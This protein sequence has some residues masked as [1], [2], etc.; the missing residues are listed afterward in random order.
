V[1]AACCLLAIRWAVDQ[2]NNESVLFRESERFG[3]GLWFRHLVRDR[4]AMPTAGEA[5]LCGVLLLIIRF[6]AG[7]VMPPPANW[8][9]FFTTTLIV[10]IALIAAPACLMAIVLTRRPLVALSLTR[11]SFAATLPAAAILALLLHPAMMALSLVIETLYPPSQAVRQQLKPILAYIVEQPVWQVLLLIA[12][13]PAI[14]E[15]LA[16][17]GFIL[18]GFRRLGHKWGAIA[19]ASMFFG[20]THFMLQQS[21]SAFA[22][23]II[24]GYVA[25]KTGSVLPGM[26]YHVTHN[27]LSVVLGR[28]TA[29]TI[30]SMPALRL[31]YQP[32]GEEGFVYQWPAVVIAAA[33]AA[34]VLWWF[35]KLPYRLSAEER[36]QEAL[37]HQVQP[38]ACLST[39]A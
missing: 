3:I 4:E 15:E 17:R 16:F 8:P 18:S 6:F 35:K 30:E 5:V 28:M 37:D 10:Q 12:V 14:C 13:A 26:L 19:L 22:V 34:G 9:Q 31:I 36:L 33:L 27:S 24:I 7:L 32:S 38:M 29:E 20:L 23:G 21:L 25:V 1:T 2:F 39:S 11:P